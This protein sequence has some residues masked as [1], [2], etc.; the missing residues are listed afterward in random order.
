[1]RDETKQTSPA[2]SVSGSSAMVSSTLALA[3]AAAASVASYNNTN[4]W[5][6]IEFDERMDEKSEKG[7]RS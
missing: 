2:V 1:M 5:S 7:R 6:A 4:E 3:D